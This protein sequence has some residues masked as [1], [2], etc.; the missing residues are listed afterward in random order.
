[1]VAALAGARQK[2]ESMMAS[3]AIVVRFFISE[4]PPFSSKVKVR[5]SLSP[6]RD[7]EKVHNMDVYKYSIGLI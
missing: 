5:F 4:N 1:M 6:E 2:T 7:K 3:M